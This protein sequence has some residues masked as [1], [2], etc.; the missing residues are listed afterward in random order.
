MA[1]IQPIAVTPTGD[2]Q[3]WKRDHDRAVN[4]LIRQLGAALSEIDYLKGRVR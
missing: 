1:D 3:Q 2:D 4:E